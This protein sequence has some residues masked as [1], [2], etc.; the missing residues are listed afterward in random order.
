MTN[1]LIGNDQITCGNVYSTLARHTDEEPEQ[2]I[3]EQGEMPGSFRKHSRWWIN[4]LDMSLGTKSAS[5]AAQ[6][7]TN[8][9]QR[10]GSQT[11]KGLSAHPADLQACRRGA[12]ASV[13]RVREASD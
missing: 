6:Q 7:T 2:A 5:C 4:Q 10:R 3:P 8:T 11:P 1:P 12:F 9:P 13:A